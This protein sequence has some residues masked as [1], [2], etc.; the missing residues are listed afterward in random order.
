MTLGGS[1]TLSLLRSHRFLAFARPLCDL[2]SS[3]STKPST[4]SYLNNPNPRNPSS[5]LPRSTLSSASTSS[6]S[7][8]P[9]VPSSTQSGAK[10]LKSAGLKKEKAGR[11]AKAALE[12]TD[13]EMDP[14]EGGDEMEERTRSTTKGKSSRKRKS[15]SS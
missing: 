7:K 4:S 11:A 9:A 6:S 5:S 13:S 10:V 2:Y 3:S 8:R 15:S 12:M 14:G 1:A